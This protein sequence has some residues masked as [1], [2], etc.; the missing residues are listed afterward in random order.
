MKAHDSFHR[1]GWSVAD[2]A[3]NSVFKIAALL[4]PLNLRQDS[5]AP[6]SLGHILIVSAFGTTI[7]IVR[8]DCKGPGRV[9]CDDVHQAAS[10][11]QV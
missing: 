9:C 4:A 3:A 11:C 7:A 6:A 8:G 1:F 2:W 5:T 10:N